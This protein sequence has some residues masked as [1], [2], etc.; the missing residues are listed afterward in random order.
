MK[1]TDTKT[2]L[3]ASRLREVLD[4]SPETG[5][6]VWKARPSVHANKG[7]IGERA[8]AVD[9][10]TG[11]RRIWIDG[12]RFVA[13]RLA[14]LWMTGEWPADLVDHIDGDKGNDRWENLRAASMSQNKANG[15]YANSP[16]G[17]KG[18]TKAGNRWRAQIVK[19]QRHQHLGYYD[20]PE[21]AHAAY[22]MAA[23]R[24]HGAFARA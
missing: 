9:K 17:L 18:V 23:D 2:I 12:D 3:T 20:T 13:H 1:A 24:L 19:D 21:A 10:G 5:V 4:Y 14:W 11:Y 7:M 16:M 22:C 6:F 15:V 8:G